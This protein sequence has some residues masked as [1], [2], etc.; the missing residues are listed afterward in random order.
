MRQQDVNVYDWCGYMYCLC[1]L[2]LNVQT[3]YVVVDIVDLPNMRGCDRK[4][5]DGHVIVVFMIVM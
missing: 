3:L 5:V 1:L 4:C 2:V